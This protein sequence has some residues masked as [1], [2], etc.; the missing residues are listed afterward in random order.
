MA[1]RVETLAPGFGGAV[2]IQDGTDLT[3]L[4]STI[5]QN[6]ANDDENTSGNAG[7]I[8]N[9]LSTVAIANTILAGNT[10]GP[11]APDDD[12]QCAGAAFTSSGFNLRSTDDT[13]CTGF[14][15]TTDLIDP[16][17]A[18]FLV[19]LGDNGGSTPTI[20]LQTGNPAIDAGNPATLG[21]A[22]P[23]CPTTDQRG[24]LRGGTA[25]VCDIGAFEFRQPT[26]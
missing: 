3:I 4:S 17:A 10:V 18:T 22:F 2:F 24:F 15:Q 21:A 5:A 16:D 20:A 6:T 25:G 14:D 12:G 11:G 9:N 26:Y 23:A 13:G 1:S 8:Y 7:G 19:P